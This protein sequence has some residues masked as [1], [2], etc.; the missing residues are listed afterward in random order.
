MTELSFLFGSVRDQRAVDLA[1]FLEALPRLCR[2]ALVDCDLGARTSVDMFVCV[3]RFQEGMSEAVSSRLGFWAWRGGGSASGPAASPLR[4][5]DKVIRAV[6]PGRLAVARSLLLLLPGVPGDLQP[7][8]LRLHLEMGAP[9]DAGLRFDR[10]RE[11]LFVPSPRSPPVGDEVD[12]RVRLP[13]GAVLDA[14][15]AVTAHR[16]AGEDGAGSPAGFVLGLIAPKPDLLD[17]LEAQADPLSGPNRRRAPRYPVRARARVS[18]RAAGESAGGRREA[19]ARLRYSRQTDLVEDYLENLSQ[20]GA[21][22]RTAEALP[23]GAPIRLEVELPDGSRVA[24]PGEVAYRNDRGVGVRFQL[25]EP[26]EAAMAE[27]VVRVASRRRRALVIDGDPFSRRGL[28][29]ALAGCGFEVFAAEDGAAGLRVLTDEMLG[30]DLLVLDAHLPGPAGGDLVE[31]IRGIGG[32]RDLAMVVV[33]GDPDPVLERRLAAAGADAVLRKD[34]G[35]GA[36]T[37]AAA[38][39]LLRGR[40]PHAA[41]GSGLARSA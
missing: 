19:V 38:R 41:A 11:A 31:F 25:D 39:A 9:E 29:D 26:G 13:D 30:L 6:P 23:V 16:A 32:E 5:C 8:A 22:V 27:A 15:A 18:L 21:F 3:V 7:D 37:E 24:A 35:P 40:R 28:G 1:A 34:Q 17:A 20:G 14:D 4:Y 36:I 12:L 33:V 10:R 2:G